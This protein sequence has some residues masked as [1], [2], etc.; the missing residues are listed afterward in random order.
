MAVHALAEDLGY[1]LAVV[2]DGHRTAAG[3]Q[4]FARIDSQRAVDGGV[5]V[6]NGHRTLHDGFRQFVGLTDGAARF[7]SAT[8]QDCAEGARMM[9]AATTEEAA[10]T[11]AEIADGA[12]E[13]G[14]AAP[15]EPDDEPPEGGGEPDGL[16]PGETGGGGGS[17]STV[18]RSTR[19]VARPRAES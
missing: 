19:R 7:Q 9:A 5:E 3:E 10:S 17:A 11:T 1:R 16:F 8:G 18:T 14:A 4:D 2:G 15:D 6:R 13:L 12:G